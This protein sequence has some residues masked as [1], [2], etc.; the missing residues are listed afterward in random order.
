[1]KLSKANMPGSP[2]RFAGQYWAGLCLGTAA[3]AR[4]LT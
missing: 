1:M 4:W 2:E 3:T